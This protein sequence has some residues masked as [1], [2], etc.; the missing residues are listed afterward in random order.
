M[1]LHVH[2]LAGCTPEPLAG[3]LKA[4]GVLRLVAAQRDPRARGWWRGDTF[5]L[6][7][8]LEPEALVAFFLREYS[9]TPLIAPWNGGSGFYPKDK[10]TGIDA[11]ASSKA[12]RFRAYRDAIQRA[13]ALIQGWDEA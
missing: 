11:I 13:Q 8:E 3:Y 1:S 9:P 6:A 12:E 10:K 4:L 7:T 2:D 5:T